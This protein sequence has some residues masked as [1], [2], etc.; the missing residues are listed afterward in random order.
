GIFPVADER[1]QVGP[2]LLVREAGEIGDRPAGEG[3]ESLFRVRKQRGKDLFRKLGVA[4]LDPFLE[5]VGGAPCQG[6]KIAEGRHHSSP[7]ASGS[8]TTPS[9]LALPANSAASRAAP[10]AQAGASSMSRILSFTNSKGSFLPWIRRWSRRTCQPKRERT[11]SRPVVPSAML[12]I[13]CSMLGT[14]SPR[15]SWPREPP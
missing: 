2:G 3:R 5:A 15:R 6:Q 9:I 4:C 10:R 12:A 7:S 1:H 14:S 8:M 13:A 11:T